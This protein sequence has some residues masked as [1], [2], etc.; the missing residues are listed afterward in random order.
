VNTAD[1]LT[2]GQVRRRRG[3]SAR[4]II[5]RTGMIGVLVVLCIILAFVAPNFLTANNLLD[6]A[7]QASVTAILAA[8]A[9]LVILTG[10]IDLSAGSALGVCAMVAMVLAVGGAGG[11]V[12]VLLALVA[13]AVIGLVNG[14]LV[15]WARLPA[16]IVT[17]AALTYL[18]GIVYIGTGATTI[19]SPDLSFAWI[20]QGS[21]LGIPV[22]IYL[23]AIVF[24]VGWFVLSRTVF[25]RQVLVIGGSKEVARLAGIPVRR[26]LLIVYVLAGLCAGIAGVISA[27][28]LQSATPVLGT[29]YELSA[30]AAV[31]LGG[32]SLEGGRGSFAGTLAGAL[33][34]GVLGN[35]L[36]LM[37]VPSFYQLVVQG[38]VILLAVG[39][40]R[41][42]RRTDTA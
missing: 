2:T 25:G 14:M 10:G 35:G 13:G 37:N 41:L 28:R 42:R 39:L 7:R 32:T 36:T 3:L 1:T 31:V 40:D 5:D 8:G 4:T 27:A 18:R 9:T 11:V 21:L 12:A 30:I 26:T 20:G 38:A 17:L 19:F 23:M 29:G 24:L 16:F 6:V 33:I 34:I 15:A 22:P